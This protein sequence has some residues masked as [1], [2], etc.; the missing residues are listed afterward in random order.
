MK[1]F[2]R[3]KSVKRDI[4]DIETEVLKQF[5]A[6]K[7]KRNKG[8]ECSLKELCRRH[9]GEVDGG[10]WETSCCERIWLKKPGRDR[11]RE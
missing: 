7:H 6:G 2:Y 3:L 8:R 1:T 10:N 9:A 11:F 4:K 5:S